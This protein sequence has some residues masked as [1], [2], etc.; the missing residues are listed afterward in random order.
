MRAC[1]SWVPASRSAQRAS[2]CPLPVSH[3]SAPAP[4]TPRAG[5]DGRAA[6][7]APPVG[8]LG[9]ARLHSTIR[10]WMARR[11]SVEK[12]A[13]RHLLRERVLE[14]VLRIGKE[15]GLVQELRR[16][17][18]RETGGA[19]SSSVSSATAWNRLNG[20]SFPMTAADLQQLLLRRREPVDPGGQ[21]G[22]DRGR[23]LNRGEGLRETIGPALAHQA[24]SSPRGSARS[25]PERTGCLPSAG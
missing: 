21:D 15:A 5:R 16:L 22:L 18:K 24:P 25:L 11:R 6:R 17:Q 10:A 2:L 20:T 3:R 1:S 8:R 13:I 9:V 23:N 19:A 12:A 4:T 7:P 14:G